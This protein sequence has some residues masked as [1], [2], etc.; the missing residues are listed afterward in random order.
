MYSQ[1]GVPTVT[2]GIKTYMQVDPTHL[3][4]IQELLFWKT[5]LKMFSIVGCFAFKPEYLVRMP[6]F[7]ISPKQKN[8]AKEID[9]LEAQWV[10]AI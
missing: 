5:D 1:R 8:Q 9:S 7:S 10:I 4:T 6:C 2:E 3:I